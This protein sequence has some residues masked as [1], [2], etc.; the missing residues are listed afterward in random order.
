MTGRQPKVPLAGDRADYQMEK[1]YFHKLGPV[2][3]VLLSVSLNFFQ[4]YR[5]QRAV[6]RL[7]E[8]VVVTA[9]VLR[10]GHSVE[11]PSAG[12]VPGE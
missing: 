4:V 7:R 3:W 6:E 1:R 9:Q 5:S 2:V 10:D 8:A 11:V 12:V